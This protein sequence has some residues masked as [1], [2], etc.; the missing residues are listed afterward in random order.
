MAIKAKAKTYLIVVLLGALAVA[1]WAGEEERSGFQNDFNKFST[2]YYLNP[3]PERVPAMF[4][5]FLES[6][7]FTNKQN[8]DE[9]CRDLIVYFFARA[10]QL[11][12]KLLESYKFLF[13]NG[14]QKQR[15][16]ILK[17]L[18]RCGDQEIRKFFISKLSEA[19]FAKEE[20]Q[21]TRALKQGI[22][23]EFNAL[24]RPVT[25]VGDLD[26]LWTEF[27]IT[28][29]EEAVVKIIK[30]LNQDSSS[31]E[32]FLLVGAAKW[33]LGAN[34]KEHKKLFEICKQELS[35]T[36]GVIK[37]ALEE[38][39]EQVDDSAGLQRRIEERRNEKPVTG[40]KAWA[41]GASALLIERNHSRHD[42]LSPNPINE[43]NIQSNRKLLDEWWG[44]NSRE[45][46][47]DSL[48][49]LELGGHRRKFEG[50]GRYFKL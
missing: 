13:E 39:I 29:N 32:S 33:S 23:T 49:W 14:T 18:Q 37:D 12:P 27:G 36:N 40:V 44:I 31:A 8:C 35:K 15:L 38:I 17:I 26:F 21:I 30:S 4:K 3:E 42:F 28:G 5:K 22:P 24:T 48:R 2:Y 6:E 1:C 16:F 41:L 50:W 46:L 47:F 43:K 7:L 9:H 45:D 10:A 19:R 11:E 34:C 25:K 20:K